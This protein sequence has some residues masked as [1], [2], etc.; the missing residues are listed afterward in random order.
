M[1]VLK[2]G[3]TGVTIWILLVVILRAT[4]TFFTAKGKPVGVQNGASQANY[5]TLKKV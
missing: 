4:P 1:Q 3:F 2:N 5:H